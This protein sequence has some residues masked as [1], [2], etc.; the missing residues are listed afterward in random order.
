MGAWQQFCTASWAGLAWER[1]SGHLCCFRHVALTCGS[2]LLA[3]TPMTE[4]SVQK[5]DDST[6]QLHV[7]TF[8]RQCQS[9]RW[10][11]RAKI[12]SPSKTCPFVRQRPRVDKL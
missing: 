7:S 2:R 11:D 3:R 8:L 10:I 1:R 9:D 6:L 4:S 5:A 12:A